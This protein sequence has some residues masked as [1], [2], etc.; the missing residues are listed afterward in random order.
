MKKFDWNHPAITNY[1]TACKEMRP[2]WYTLTRE[3]ID[4]ETKYHD[5][6]TELRKYLDDLGLKMPQVH[7]EDKKIERL[8]FNRY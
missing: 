7:Y 6:L 8:M 3:H 1:V 4:D 2:Y 5:A